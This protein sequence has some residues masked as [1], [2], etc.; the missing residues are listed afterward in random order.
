V[1]TLV[2]NERI[3]LSDAMRMVF[4]INSLANATPATVSRAGILYI[5]EADV[6][7]EPAVASWAA[8]RED[9]REREVLPAL[10]TKYVGALAAA[11]SRGFET[12][13]PLRVISQAQS[14]CHLLE[15]LLARAALGSGG[16]EG[17]GGEGMAPEKH[18]FECEQYVAFAA[19]WAFGGP[20]DAESRK[21]FHELWQSSSIV[22]AHKFAAHSSC[23]DFVFHG[24][25]WKA[26]SEWVPAFEPVTIGSGPLDVAFSSIVVQTVDTTRLGHVVELLAA[27]GHGAMLVGPAGTGKTTVVQ[28]FLGGLNVDVFQSCVI[29][30][31]YFTDSLLLQ[32]QLEKPVEKRSGRVFGPPAGKHLV[33]FIDDINLPYVETYGT[34]NAIELLRQQADHKS[35]FD[36]VDLGFRREVVDCQYLAAMNPKSGS[37]V[38]SERL[39]RHFATFS[40]TMPG[41]ADLQAIYG[42]IFAGHLDAFPSK[43]AKLAQAASD[44]TIALHAAV[45]LKFLPS[46]TKLVYNWD[47]RE[48]SAVFQGLTL[49]DPSHKAYEHPV[50]LVRLWSHECERVFAD[51]LLSPPE[52]KRFAEMLVG[53]Q[54]KYFTDVDFE[55]AAVKPNI[56]TTFADAKAPGVYLGAE[57]FPALKKV[58]E[59]KLVEHN[60]SRAMMELALFEQAMEHV[61]RIARILG[62]P[63]GNAMLIGV[64][65]SGKQSL[66]RLAGFICNCE[67]RQ[68]SV[69]SS[70]GVDDL[71][72]AFKEMYKLAGVKVTPLLLLMTDSQIVDERFLVLINDFLSSGWVPDLFP[73][74]ELDAVFSALRNEAKA[75]GVPDSPKTMLEF[76]VQR[77][78]ANL[79]LALCFSPVGAAFRTRARRF[80][81]IFSC[82]AID[83]FHS[84]PREALVSVAQR[85]L[86]EVE[87]QVRPYCCPY[88]CPSPPPPTPC[89]AGSQLTPLPPLPSPPTALRR[90]RPPRTSR[91]TRRRCTSPS[92]RR[93]RASCPRRSASTT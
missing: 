33:V 89:C 92:S 58:L 93:A 60:E 18:K 65:G 3:P 69:T 86:A 76:F 74:D 36:R 8:R 57:S 11:L 71:R 19:I 46:A 1:L 56:F 49:A 24:G 53:M 22:G 13:T 64:G 52:Q 70:Y 43:V 91:T 10:L 85:F 67:L 38:V 12:V 80:P 30:M 75:A 45:M 4:E 39:Q 54:K 55:E 20:L 82:T 77:V 35:I 15:E 31:N 66:A 6:G 40:C 9:A 37:F 27:R 32:Q 25:E 83:W 81:G 34:Q 2:S 62:N 78:R 68:L 84:W 23:F 7:W 88:C 50:T 61:C 59:A 41:T 44:A 21:A 87:L 51:R 17:S 16:G 5:N 28:T 42:E 14:V 48:L 26:W 63:R 73:A 79:H 72:E 90:P 29:N 47:M